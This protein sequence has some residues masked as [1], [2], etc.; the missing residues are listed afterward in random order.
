MSQRQVK[1]C[2]F[3]VGQ[4]AARNPDLTRRVVEEGHELGNH[5]HTHDV[6]LSLRTRSRV[7]RELHEAQAVFATQGWRPLCF[8]PPVGIVN[9]RLWPALLRQGLFAVGFSRRAMDW[10]NRKV[11]GLAG[12]LLRGVRGGDILLLHDCPGGADFEV[13]TWLQEVE[14]VL[15]G[16]E[17]RGLR[18]APLSELIGRPV[19]ERTAPD[20]AS[21]GAAAA[22]YDGLASAYDQEQEARG[23]AA[24][25]GPELR[26]VE[27]RLAQVVSEEDRVLELGAGTGRFTVELARR[28]REVTAL[29]VSAGML[30]RLEAR[31]RDAGLENITP[32]HGAAEETELNGPYDLVCS[33][34]ALEYVRDLDA[35]LKRLADVMAPGG[36]LLFTTAHSGPIRLWVQLGNAMRQGIWLHARSRAE[37]RRALKG[38]GL[39]P[40]VLETHALKLPLFGGMF[41]EVVA[42]KP[43]N[44]E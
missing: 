25:R 35:L 39:E 44:R 29:D 37:V 9:P 31:A 1:A 32:L 7:S 41:L 24:V 5:T 13:E 18:V 38:A 19:M 42:R 21:H 20:G 3:Q 8:R 22:F 40:E 17:A 11:P 10:G 12:R 16:L 43:E 36:K 34:S 15:D 26:V 2:F 14:E 6:L 30:A 4:K 28:A 23:V 33:F 27:A